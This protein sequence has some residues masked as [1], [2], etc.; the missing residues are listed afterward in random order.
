MEI[1][2]RPFQVTDADCI[3]TLIQRN[4]LEVNSKDYG[5]EKMEALACLYDA[6]KVLHV[7]S[8]A[9]FYVVSKGERIVGCGAISSFWGKPDESILLTI[10][11]DPD[12]HGNG[13]GTT[14]MH[15]LEQDE[16][17]LRAKRI[18]IPSSIHACSFYQHFGYDYK[19]YP[20][21]LDEEGYYRLEKKRTL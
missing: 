9:H 13:I 18:E 15:T 21:Q 11:V 8:Y 2:I 10:F 16:Y 14:I 17:Y 7:A 12:L 3:A 19:D 20:I 6:Q 1:T 4:L 5:L